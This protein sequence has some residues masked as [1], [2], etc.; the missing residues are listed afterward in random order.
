ME[1]RFNPLRFFPTLGPH[2]PVLRVRDGD[3]V[4]TATVDSQGCDHRGE[5]LAP[6]GNPQTG[7]F[8]VEGVEPGDAL[9]VR[10]VE[11]LPNRT[12][13]YC[14]SSISPRVVDPEYVPEL[15]AAP[16]ARWHVD[17][18]AGTATLVAPESKLGRLELPLSP[19]LGCFG[20]APRGGQT[21]S[22]ITAAEH[23]GN[24]D[25]NGF[26]AGTTAYLPVFEPGAL[27]FLGDGHAAQG[28][29]EIAGTGIEISM[30]VRFTVS[31][32][33][34]EAPVRWPRGED[35]EWI[36]TVGNACPLE[37]ATRAATTEMLRWL[38]SD[39]H[40][41]ALG[42]HL[43]LGQGVRYDLGHVGGAVSTVVCKVKKSLLPERRQDAS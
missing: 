29:G 20:V 15:P 36:F 21:L 7:P 34:T 25:Y 12:D 30:D 33:R 31:R 41:D 11:I 5:S 17:S 13:G 8:F 38:S 19:M 40:L 39:W 27:F 14:R 26:T 16:L 6:R 24:M 22:T 18:G 35:E 2:E 37:S 43:L 23:G 3:S 32:V 28:D 10:F 1:H 9:A 42:A 4:V